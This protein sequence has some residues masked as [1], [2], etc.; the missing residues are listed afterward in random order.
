MTHVLGIDLSSFGIELVRL[1][2]TSRHAGW[3]HI[4]LQGPDALA[5]LRDLP[6]RMPR[7][8]TTFYDDIYLV[9]VELPMGRGE[10]GTQAKLN[11][12]FGA[13]VTCIPPHLEIWAVAPHEWRRELQLPGNAPKEAGWKRAV[14]L[15]AP[16]DWKDGNAYDAYSVAWAAR[17]V[18]QRGLNAA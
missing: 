5:R 12:V 8:A 10:A 7:W 4:H 6:R 16:A 3:D 13:I 15:G 9:A 17:E 2:E 1:D 14:E 11:H 18:N